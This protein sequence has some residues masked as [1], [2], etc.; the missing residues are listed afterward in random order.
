MAQIVALDGDRAG[1]LARIEHAIIE[2]SRQ[3]VDIIVFPETC[4]LGWVNP[5]AHQ[6]AHPIPGADSQQLSAWAKQHKIHICIG[7]SEKDGDRLYDSVILID[8][9]GK[10]LLKHRKINILTE[11]M[12]PPYSKGSAVEVV[13]TKFG[14]IGLLICADTFEES[15]LTQMKAKQPEL[16]LVPYG[17]AAKKEDWPVHGQELVKVVKNASKTIGCPVVGTNLVGQISQ[18]PWRGLTYGGL[19]VAYDH[20]SNQ[21][22]IGADRDRDIRVFTFEVGR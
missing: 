8:D 1:N 16:L 10:L 22:I 21:L 2:A 3:G 12:T 5:D 6:L 13:E 17:W 9:T 14:T 15:V 7:L 11:L 4:V 20:S 18:G 19:S